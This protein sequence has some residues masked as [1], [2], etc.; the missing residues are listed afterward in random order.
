MQ[1][2]WHSARQPSSKDVHL[3]LQVV[4]MWSLIRLVMV[5]LP[6]LIMM[7]VLVVMRDARRTSEMHQ[8]SISAH[9]THVDVARLL[10]VRLFPPVHSMSRCPVTPGSQFTSLCAAGFRKWRGGSSRSIPFQGPV[11]WDH[12]CETVNPCLA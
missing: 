6:L 10:Q 11:S 12:R 1:D 7:R 5:F 3:D 4:M 9:A 2:P 8:D